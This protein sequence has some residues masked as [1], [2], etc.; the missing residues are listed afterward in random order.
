MRISE[1]VPIGVIINR[2]FP[3][4]P[5]SA[6]SINANVVPVDLSRR[7]IIRAGQLGIPPPK[8]RKPRPPQLFAAREPEG[9]ERFASG[10]NS[11]G[12]DAATGP[13]HRPGGCNLRRLDTELPV[14]APRLANG[15]TEPDRKAPDL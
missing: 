10:I 12:S 2:A 3:I 15:A 6:V 11:R 5:P 14:T 8:P 1:I 7:S 9:G 13:N 4:E